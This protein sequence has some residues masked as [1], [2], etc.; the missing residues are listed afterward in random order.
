MTL[1]CSRTRL[2][3][4]M[5]IINWGGDV[6]EVGVEINVKLSPKSRYKMQKSLLGNSAA[7]K[8]NR[9]RM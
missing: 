2:E 3:F 8:A 7:G 5:I 9:A 1:S 6:E 4:K